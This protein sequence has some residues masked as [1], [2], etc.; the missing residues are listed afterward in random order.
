MEAYLF[1][2]LNVDG[3]GG[4][5][6]T[7]MGQKERLPMLPTTPAPNSLTKEHLIL[8]NSKQMLFS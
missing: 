4:P 3:A 8:T 5:P 1:G 6:V 7:G 2:E